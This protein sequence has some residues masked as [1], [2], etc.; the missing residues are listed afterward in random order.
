MLSDYPCSDVM[1]CT[2]WR[3]FGYTSCVVLLLFCLF[4]DQVVFIDQSDNMRVEVGGGGG[5]GKKKKGWVGKKDIF[6]SCEMLS[7]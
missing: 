6:W 1:Y 4:T 2:Y 3:C 5:G 7:D